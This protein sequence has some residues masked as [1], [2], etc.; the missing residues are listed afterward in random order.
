M[1]IALELET[2]EQTYKIYGGSAGFTKIIQATGLVD[3]DLTAV[4]ILE[5]ISDLERRKAIMTILLD[6]GEFVPEIDTSIDRKKLITKLAKQ[7]DTNWIMSLVATLVGE[8]NLAAGSLSNIIAI[9]AQT[10]PIQEEL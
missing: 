3:T 2:R 7:L 4:K 10:E 6:E 8:M 9:A 5:V 1:A